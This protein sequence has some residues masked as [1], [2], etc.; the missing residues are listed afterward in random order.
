MA[1][2]EGASAQAPMSLDNVTVVIPVWNGA[3]VLGDCLRALYA[4]SGPRLRG[5][6]AVDNDSADES[7]ALIEREFPG[8]HLLRSAF[9]VGFAG[10]VNAGIE[11]AVTLTPTWDAVVLLNQDCIVED[12]WLDG[13]C[14]GMAADPQ[15]AIGGCTILNADG[16][17]NHAGARL[18]GP[19]AFSQHLTSVTEAPS[20][21][22]YVTGAAFAIRRSAWNAIGPLDEDFFPAYY[23]EADYCYRARRHGWGVL[24]VPAAR[25]RHLQTS[26]AWRE[27]PLLYWAQQHRSRYRF[28]AKHFG[29]AELA[30]FFT[31]EY[32]AVEAEEWFDQWMGRALAA[33]HTLRGLDATWLRRRQELDECPALADKR[34]LQVEL[35]GIAQAAL[36]KATAYVHRDLLAKETELEAKREELREAQREA[37][38]RSQR[39]YHKLGLMH[40]EDTFERRDVHGET[41]RAAQLYVLSVLT[42]YD[43]R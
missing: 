35:A 12:G 33:R 20:R 2:T 28:V 14:A 25:V 15:A 10:G 16:S 34:R 27:D 6:I 1:Q 17:V 22:E 37:R 19:S 29:G 4:G 23:E 39:M 32:A 9:N 36:R 18:Q 11:A 26:Q 24:Y 43:Y 7:A 41:L 3:E 30:A 8:V 42:E 40:V 5:V 21:M 31:A 13:L 38:T